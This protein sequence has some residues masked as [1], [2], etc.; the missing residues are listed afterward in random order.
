M[1]YFIPLD[2]SFIL[3]DMASSNFSKEE[4]KKDITID[5]Q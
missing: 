1:T 4:N 5:M 2:Y 3:Y